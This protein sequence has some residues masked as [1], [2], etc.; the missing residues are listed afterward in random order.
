MFEDVKLKIAQ[1]ERSLSEIAAETSMHHGPMC[2]CKS[3]GKFQIA[4]ALSRSFRAQEKICDGIIADFSS[5]RILLEVY[6]SEMQGRPISV[7]DIC[8]A[9]SIPMATSI[10][11]LAVLYDRKLL[12]RIPDGMDKRRIW[13]EMTDFGKTCL[14]AWL[15]DLST[16]LHASSKELVHRSGSRQA[17]SRLA[18]FD[19]TTSQ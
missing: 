15:S 6:V 19:H 3:I 16:R 10:R 8:L 1:I 13:L 5:W 18:T 4:E 11:W 12:Q 14:E 9:T 17:M 2:S 7:S